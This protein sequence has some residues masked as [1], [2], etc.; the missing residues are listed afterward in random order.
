M[1]KPV[2]A[3]LEVDIK[4]THG[5]KRSL[6]SAMDGVAVGLGVGRRV[7]VGHGV[8]VGVGCGVAVG[9]GVAVGTGV[10]VGK[11]VAVGIGVAVG[12]DAIT[13]RTSSWTRTA[14]VASM[15][16]VGVGFGA[17]HPIPN[18]NRIPI[19]LATLCKGERNYSNGSSLSSIRRTSSSPPRT[20]PAGSQFS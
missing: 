4:T 2:P 19:D 3:P 20:L 18:N 17:T 7:A 9:N 15:F 16:G 14:K 13:V 10:G 12:T 1:K 6:H 11:G 8:R 5:S